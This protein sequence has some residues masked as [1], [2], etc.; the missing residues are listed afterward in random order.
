MPHIMAIGHN[1]TLTS[2]HRLF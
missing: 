2:R 1:F